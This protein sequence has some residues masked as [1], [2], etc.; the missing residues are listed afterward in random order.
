[1]TLLMGAFCW[2]RA[3]EVMRKARFDTP[4]IRYDT[5]DLNQVNEGDLFLSPARLFGNLLR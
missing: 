4:V 1:M 5:G 2:S 3:G